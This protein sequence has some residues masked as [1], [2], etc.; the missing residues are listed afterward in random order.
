[1]GTT[2]PSTLPTPYPDNLS[3][4]HDKGMVLSIRSALTGGD[5]PPHPGL[6]SLSSWPAGRRSEHES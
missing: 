5:A 1:M 2:A 4:Q 3:Q 6:L